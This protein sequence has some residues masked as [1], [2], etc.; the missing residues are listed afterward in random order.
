MFVRGGG[1][2]DGTLGGGLG[3]IGQGV[4]VGEEKI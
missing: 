1:V 2:V 4:L 3:L